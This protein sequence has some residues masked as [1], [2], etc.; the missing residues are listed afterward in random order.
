METI[1]EIDE[2]LSFNF[3]KVEETT[4]ELVPSIPIHGA[5]VP[6][7][8]G[9]TLENDF[10]KSREMYSDLLDQGRDALAEIIHIAGET[11]H[12]RAYEVAF[13]GLKNIGELGEKLMDIHKKRKDVQGA[14]MPDFG[15]GKTNIENMNAVFV[16][17]LA[18]LQKELGSS[19]QGG[20]KEEIIEM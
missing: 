1:L 17:S 8:V 16:G 12:P 11:N 3:G 7:E 6:V 14:I 4:Q 2:Q 9:N 13:Q 10:E 20:V 18:E 5:M 19:G 15:D